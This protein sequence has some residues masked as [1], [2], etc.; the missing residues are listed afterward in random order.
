MPKP[1]S[2]R[3][4]HKRCC[5][6]YPAYRW[7]SNRRVSSDANWK[8]NTIENRMVAMWGKERQWS[9]VVDET[10]ATIYGPDGDAVHWDDPR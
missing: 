8:E 9:L 3:M 4:V 5:D 2:L 1:I 7:L 10:G 6:A